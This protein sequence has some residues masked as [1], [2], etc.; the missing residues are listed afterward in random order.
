VI[1]AALT[2]ARAGL[3]VHPVRADKKPYT[4]WGTD[5][6]TSETKILAWWEY[7]WPDA[8]V[9][10][11][12]GNGLVVVDVD[13]R[14]G[15]EYDD[16]LAATLTATTPG[17]GWHHWFGTTERIGN[18]VGILP[19]VDVRGERGYVL[20][21]G[22]PGYEWV[23]PDT[24]MLPLP[25]EV[26]RI[27]RSQRERTRNGPGFEPAEPGSIRE[28]QRHDYMVR[29]AGWAIRAFELE[30]HHELGALCLEE[31][32]RACSPADAP[33]ENILRIARSILQRDRL[34]A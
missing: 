2:Y 6:T 4:K 7:H 19:G 11:C 27:Q 14:H 1:E 8:L 17:G 28:G 12:T 22:N 24:P 34:S 10:V 30:H 25:A 26:G 18:A 9:A 33:D 32:H 16:E 5:A 20:A 31:Y 21:P 23:D 3:R 29:F 13:P 15:G